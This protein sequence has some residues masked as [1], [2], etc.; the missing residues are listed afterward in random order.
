MKAELYENYAMTLDSFNLENEN[1]QMCFQMLLRGQR[2]TP[3]H[4]EQA[5]K[6]G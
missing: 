2:N 6:S 5:A 4:V 3:H 1:P